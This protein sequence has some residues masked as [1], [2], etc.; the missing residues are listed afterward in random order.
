M[1]QV[2]R[3]II[4]FSENLSWA[5]EWCQGHA[6]RAQIA[7]QYQQLLCDFRADVTLAP[8]I[9]LSIAKE[10]AFEGSRGSIRVP[11]GFHGRGELKQWQRWWDKEI[12][13]KCSSLKATETSAGLPR[14]IGGE[15][16]PD[17]RKWQLTVQSTNSGDAGKPGRNVSCKEEHQN[18]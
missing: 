11:G 15:T 3:S 6:W 7:L 8:K 4:C 10:L 9:N 16:I 14:N 5:W 2:Q 1:E 18:A 13:G 12:L 17:D